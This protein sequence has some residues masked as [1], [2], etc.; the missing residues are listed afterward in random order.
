MQF[1]FPDVALNFYKQDAFIHDDKYVYFASPLLLQV[2]NIF[3]SI[4]IC[5]KHML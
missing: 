2:I 4:E 1:L 3:A 5:L